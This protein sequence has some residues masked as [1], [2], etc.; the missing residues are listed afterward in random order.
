MIGYSEFVDNDG[1]YY[2]SLYCEWFEEHLHNY[3]QLDG[4]RRLYEGLSFEQFSLRHNY[5]MCD[6]KEE[7]DELINDK[8]L[9]DIENEIKGKLK[10]RLDMV[11]FF[12]LCIFVNELVREHYLVLLKCPTKDIIS[13]L[14]EIEEITFTDKEGRSATTNCTKLINAIM[15]A[16]KD[17]LNS[18]GGIMETEKFGRYDNMPEVVEVS[19]LQSKFAYYLALFL[20]KAFPDANRSHR[21]KQGIIS[22]VEQKL[23]LRMMSYF[24]LA[25]KGYTLT[26]ARFRKL[27]ESYNN[28][29]FPIQY[30]RA[31]A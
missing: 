13:E 4:D 20:N 27:M 30:Q 18:E 23:I 24:G 2:T 21:G 6:F 7:L 9:S 10:I 22:P 17:P 31:G 5:Q 16:I 15:S 12:L 19:V 8:E 25:P 14:S 3:Y 28:L 11:N 26:T 29:N 1:N